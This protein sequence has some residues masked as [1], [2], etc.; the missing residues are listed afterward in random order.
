MKATSK[1]ES[2]TTEMEVGSMAIVNDN[3]EE[4]ILIT[5][6]QGNYIDGV[7]ISTKNIGRA[8][9]GWNKKNIKVSPMTVTITQKEF[10]DILTKA[11]PNI[12]SPN[13][14]DRS[15]ATEYFTENYTQK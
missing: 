1:I 2:T 4:V 3:T 5:D 15:D 10:T 12:P 7:G 11:L 13:R 14:D 9:M 8:Y 6:M